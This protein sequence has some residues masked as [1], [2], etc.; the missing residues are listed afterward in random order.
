MRFLA[1]LFLLLTFV[2]PATAQTQPPEATISATLDA[3]TVV[4]LV[5][6]AERADDGGESQPD[7]DLSATGHAR[8][9][10]LATLLRDAGLTHIHSTDYE[11]TQQTAAPIA[12]HLGAD[13][14]SY[15]PRALSAF[16]DYLAA[17]PGRHLVVGHSNTT[18]AL[19]AALDGE[20]GPAIEHDEYDRLYVVYLAPGQPV[21]TTLLRF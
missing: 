6:H 21:V 3:P 14:A 10:R 12:T 17:T 9:E 20:P 11:R 8:A 15:D 19:V 18:P 5:R 4:F 7:P 1:T 16:A 2:L 13:V